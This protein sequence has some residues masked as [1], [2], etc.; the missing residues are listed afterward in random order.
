MSDQAK[1]DAALRYFES[2]GSRGV[3]RPYRHGIAL[4]AAY[5]E[6]Q[7]QVHVQKQAVRRLR[8]VIKEMRFRGLPPQVDLLAAQALAGEEMEQ[9]G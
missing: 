2:M 8:W 1:I 3:S 6:Q 9:D 7:E 5:R 4:A